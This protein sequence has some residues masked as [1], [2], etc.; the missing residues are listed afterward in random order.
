MPAIKTTSRIATEL[1]SDMENQRRALGENNDC[2]VKALAAVTGTSYETAR[3]ALTQAGRKPGRGCTKSDIKGA[4][5]ILGFRGETCNMGFFVA[6]YPG[7]H[8]GLKNVTTH[9]PERFNK[10]WADGNNYLFY[11]TGHVAGIVNGVNHDWTK[12]RAK[13]VTEIW[14]I[15][16]K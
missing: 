9:H 1:F 8:S 3:D 4:L 2:S 5:D 11:T 6:Q 16:P 14:V 10:V 7:V 13:R 12:G 15:I